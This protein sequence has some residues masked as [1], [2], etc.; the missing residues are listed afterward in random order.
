MIFMLMLQEAQHKL[1]PAAL[2][3]LLRMLTAIPL[4]PC[5]MLPLKQT[6]T[7]NTLRVRNVV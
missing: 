3:H 1:L 4:L 2:P 6:A 5:K 7:G